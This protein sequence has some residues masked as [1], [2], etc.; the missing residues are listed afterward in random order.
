MQGI[1]PRDRSWRLGRLKQ[2]KRQSQYSIIWLITQMGSRNWSH[3]GYSEEPC[4]I[5]LCHWRSQKSSV[6]SGL[7][8]HTLIR[9]CPWSRVLFTYTK[10]YFPASNLSLT[11]PIFSDHFILEPL[12]QL[13]VDSDLRVVCLLWKQISP[14][15]PQDFLH[16]SGIG[17]MVKLLS[18]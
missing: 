12:L 17:R 13:S 6:S 16:H 14:F 8:S 9:G 7:L 1:I 18:H 10:N 11:S 3:W 15:Q 5:H 2:G 4:T